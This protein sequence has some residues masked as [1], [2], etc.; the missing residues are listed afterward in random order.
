[1]TVPSSLNQSS[2]FWVNL[3]LQ[4]RELSGF[5]IVLIYLLVASILAY[6]LSNH[7][8]RIY[9]GEPTVFSR[10]AKP[11]IDFFEKMLGPV[12]KKKMKLRDYVLSFVF[13]NLVAGVV[14][15]LAIYFQNYVPFNH[16]FAANNFSLIINTVVSFLTNTNL[17]HYSNPLRFTYFSQT[18]VLIGLMY[19]GPATAFAVSM[20]FIRGINTEEGHLGNFFHDLLVSFFELII[21]LSLILTVVLIVAGIPETT[22]YYLTVHPLFS[23]STVNLPLGPVSSWESIKN[24]GTNGGGF[25]G[26][27]AGFP[28][29]NPNWF[30]NILEFSAFT[31]IPLASI[32]SLGK[33]FSSRSFGRMLY[34]VVMGIFLFSALVAFFGEYIGIPSFSGLGMAY[35]GNMVG[36][37]TAIGLASSTTFGVGATMTSTGAA[38]ALLA[39]YTPTGMLGIII[40]LLMNDP[41]GGVG[42]SVLN[43]FTFVIFTAFIASLM[44]GRLP[45]MMRIKLGSKEIKYSTLS[46][47]THPLLVLIPLGVTFTLSFVMTSFS[48]PAPFRVTALLYEFGTSAANN[49]SE[50]G[51]FLT[52]QD[53]FNYLDALIMLIGRYFIMIFQLVIAQSLAGKSPRSEGENAVRLG[54]PAFGFTLFAV[55]IVVGVLSFF[56]VLALGP[57]LSLAK[58]FNLFIWRV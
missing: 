54:S 7:I 3:F 32:M 34:M 29:E 42:T 8:A 43:L 10:Y 1:L 39:A 4:N 20:A 38:D 40:P 51:T 15:I 12:A 49:G 9:R 17:Q 26:A 58:D 22:M 11:F 30:T 2:S 37:E 13:F 31:L 33:V 48:N 28:L 27:N 56:P 6:I 46:L 35:T 5:I 53:Y 19:I 57:L 36:K 25:Y 18:F 52:N 55:M 41:L 45:E 24:L 16:A 50:I 14:A 44:V 21:P 47:V 23:G